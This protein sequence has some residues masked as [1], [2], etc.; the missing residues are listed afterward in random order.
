MS[1]LNPQ[2]KEV[3]IGVSELREIKIYPLSIHSQ[4]AM[5]EEIQKVLKN[6]FALTAQTD[7]EEKE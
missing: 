1:D 4:Q 5:G 6:F 2:I 3:K 7:E